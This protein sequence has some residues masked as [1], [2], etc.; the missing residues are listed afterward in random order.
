M[1]LFEMTYIQGWSPKRQKHC[2]ALIRY[3]KWLCVSAGFPLENYSTIYLVLCS[4]VEQ[5]QRIVCTAQ[6]SHEVVFLSDM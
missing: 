1:L 6:T 5:M 4:V 3:C 2:M